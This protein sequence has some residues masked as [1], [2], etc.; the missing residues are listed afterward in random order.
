LTDLA[1]VFLF[2]RFERELEILEKEVE[3]IGKDVG[4]I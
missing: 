2:K 1:K 4:K 3:V